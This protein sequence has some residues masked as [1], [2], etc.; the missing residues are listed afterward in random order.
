M[1]LTPSQT[2]VYNFKEHPQ[3]V[4]DKAVKFKVLNTRKILK[5]AVI[6]SFEVSDRVL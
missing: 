3:L 6:G 4:M 1:L 2:L 5:D